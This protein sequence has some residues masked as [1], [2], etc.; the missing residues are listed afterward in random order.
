MSFAAHY[1]LGRP[2]VEYNFLSRYFLMSWVQLLTEQLD[3]A[4]LH[5]VIRLLVGY[6]T[7]PFRN[8]TTLHCA[9]MKLLDR[10]SQSF[11]ET[12]TRGLKKKYND[13]S[14][15]HRVWST[16]K[17]HTWPQ[18]CKCFYQ[19]QSDSIVH[20]GHVLYQRAALPTYHYHTLHIALL[21]TYTHTW[22]YYHTLHMRTL[23]IIPSSHIARQLITR[24]QSWQIVSTKVH[25]LKY[26]FL[27]ITIILN[28]FHDCFHAS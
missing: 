17:Y 26:I 23:L 14:G 7:E 18:Q 2:V 15:Y 6:F 24:I 20:V 19:V 13:C 21:Y 4:A 16:F 28:C 1:C 10:P 3:K 27:L 25:L 11:L 8:E 5:L 12:V 9:P 22:Y